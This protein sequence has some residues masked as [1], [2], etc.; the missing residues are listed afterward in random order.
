MDTTKTPARALALPF[1]QGT[2]ELPEGACWLR[3]EADGALLPWRERL[4]CEQS[5]KPA[6]D[7]LRAR[8]WRVAPRLERPGGYRAALVLLTKHKGESRGLIARA[9]DLL[10]PDGVLVCAGANALG[11]ASLEKETRALVGLDGHLSKHQARVFWRRRPAILPEGLEGWRAG[12][13]ARPVAGTAL[14]AR[15]GCF[16]PD[17]PD[18]GSRL[19][20]EHLPSSL[21]GRGADL[22]AGWGFLSAGLLER[23]SAVTRVDLIEAEAL[24]LED[25][26]AN[27]AGFGERA[28]FFWHDALAGPPT[29][30]PCEWVVC[31]PPF[32]DGGRTDPALGLGFIATAWRA[33]RRGGRLFLVANRHLPYEALLRSRFRRVTLLAEADG[34]KV[35]GCDERVEESR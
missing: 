20:L 9:L 28:G 24:A 19:L 16:S 5:F 1:E 18:P 34:Y 29:D 22:G 26:R 35:Y 30:E 10:A 33:L 31:N 6:H 32:H 25:A 17:H 7:R 21:A 14:V 13:A 27:L 23:F 3:A 4:D 2:L 15:A 12:A 8:G 11:V